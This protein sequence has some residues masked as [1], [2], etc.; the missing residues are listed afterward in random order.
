ML[1]FRDQP[2]ARQ[3]VI[4]GCGRTG[5]SIATTLAE[6]RHFVHLL[7]PN[8]AVYDALPSSLINEGFIVPVVGDGTLEDD[9]RRASTQEA[10]VFV[11][12]SGKDAGNALAA[13]MAHHLFQVPRVI[14]R[15]GDPTSKEMYS[16]LGLST[17][18][19]A[20]MVTD[21]VLEA[22]EE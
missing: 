17:I 22:V 1:S 7:D 5:A 21:T 3:V 18:S 8:P 10:D 9:L 14:C 11:A 12:V 4:V 6:R 2:G 16:R 20:A 15:I 13:Q 19:P